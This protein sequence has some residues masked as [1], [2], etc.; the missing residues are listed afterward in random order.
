MLCQLV[1]LNE[2]VPCI[3]L[4]VFSLIVLIQISWILHPRVVHNWEETDLPVL[5]RE[6]GLEENVQ[7]PVG[8]APHTFRSTLGFHS[9]LCRVVTSYSNFCTNDLLCFTV[10]VII[11]L[12]VSCVNNDSL[13]CSYVKLWRNM[14]VKIFTVL[15]R[16]YG[17]KQIDQVQRYSSRTRF[18][19]YSYKSLATCAIN[20][21]I[22][23]AWSLN[24]SNFVHVQVFTVTS[25][26]RKVSVWYYSDMHYSC[27]L[28]IVHSSPT[29]AIIG[30]IWVIA[31]CSMN[32]GWRT[33]WEQSYIASF[34]GLKRNIRAKAWEW[35]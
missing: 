4:G 31:I 2:R 25:V 5:S 3:S 11:I 10:R 6:S 18:V 23:P 26:Y 33:A 27:F 32:C 30:C 22:P 28:L 12:L 15:A 14:I 35:D 13:L 29:A 16:I 17:S 19:Y 8:K 20:Y 7:E 24:T 34:P 21:I 1:T 9:L